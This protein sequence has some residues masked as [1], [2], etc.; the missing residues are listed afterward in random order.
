MFVTQS[1]EVYVCGSG[2]KGELGLGP[3]VTTASTPTRIPGFP[4]SGT[5]IVSIAACMSHVVVVLADG[6]VYGWGSGRKGQLGTP[7]V[8]VWSPRKIEG[9]TFPVDVAVCGR[10]FTYLVGPPDA[11]QHSVLGPDKWAIKS[12]APS[13][14]PGY[15]QVQA[16]WGSIFVLLSTG[17]LLSWGRNDHGQLSPAGLPLLRNV[18]VGSEHVVAVTRSGKVLAFGWGEHGNCGV[19]AEVSHGEREPWNEIHILDDSLQNNMQ[20]QSVAVGAGCATSWVWVCNT[21]H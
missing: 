21:A 10:E 18:A 5:T 2:L 16:S 1:N 12:S 17:Q 8:V 9:L 14:I 6:T 20:H 19:A 3:D 11:G 13:S 15:S 7:S 4:P